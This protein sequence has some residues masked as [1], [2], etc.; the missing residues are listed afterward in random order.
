MTQD[1]NEVAPGVGTD[2]N[3]GPPMC[4]ECNAPMGFD[5]AGNFVHRCARQPTE[6]QRA[7]LT[8]ADAYRAANKIVAAQN[9]GG[10]YTKEEIYSA[11]SNQ[12]E[13]RKAL[14]DAAALAD[15]PE[16]EGK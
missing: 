5:A 8:A 12:Y 13:T 7:I 9:I 2:S 16:G 6:R 1:Q 14:A 11:L 4:G 10:E 3:V 15:T